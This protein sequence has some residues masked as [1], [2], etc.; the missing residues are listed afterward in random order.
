MPFLSKPDAMGVRHAFGIAWPYRSDMPGSV[1]N[2]AHGYRDELLKST[3]D[4]RD[5]F[6]IIHKVLFSKYDRFF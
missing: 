1:V 6:H 5:I 3:V 2:K 4:N